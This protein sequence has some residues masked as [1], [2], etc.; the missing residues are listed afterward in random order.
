MCGVEPMNSA[1]RIAWREITKGI[2][3]IEWEA[4]ED[5]AIAHLAENIPDGL[6]ASV[7]ESAGPVDVGRFLDG[8]PFPPGYGDAAML[9][10]PGGSDLWRELGKSIKEGGGPL[11]TE[12]R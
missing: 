2:D 3:Q 4:M 5:A 6:L 11:G 9:N 7:L 12:N 1:E 10:S 8:S